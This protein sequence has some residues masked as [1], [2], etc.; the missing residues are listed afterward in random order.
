MPTTDDITRLFNI[1]GCISHEGMQRYCNGTLTAAEKK[2]IDTHLESCELCSDAMEGYRQHSNPEKVSHAVID[3][4]RQ[5][6]Q[7]FLIIQTRKI[8][9][10]SMLSVFSAAAT[11]I[12]IAGLFFLM[13][14]REIYR[15]RL[16]S[17]SLQDSL[18]ISDIKTSKSN[19]Y[20]DESVNLIQ[21]SERRT[22]NNLVTVRAENPD[23]G[24][25]SKQLTTESIE[26]ALVDDI[27][28]KPEIDNQKSLADSLNLAEAMNPEPEVTVTGYASK[29]ATRKQQK[30][31]QSLPAASEADNSLSEEVF[32]MAEEMPRFMN[33]DISKFR[34]FVQQQIQYPEKAVEDS[35]E[36]RVF[37]SFIINKKGKLVNPEI[38]RSADPLLDKEALRV[39][40]SSPSW[41]P[42]MMQ[43]KPVNV[44]LTIPVIFKLKQE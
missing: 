6:H 8:R 29:V 18:I 20:R 15:E 11:I 19:A 13:K 3:L 5:L 16:L 44:K 33:G 28:E 14:Q 4:N 17:Y 12:L 9:E 24:S 32:I 34:E 22:E 27:K 35:I 25:K 10:R 36:G 26:L 43:G 23:V 42:G 2:L 40:G 31:Y 21:E 38:V 30:N 39:I 37:V 7:R 41:T 1:S